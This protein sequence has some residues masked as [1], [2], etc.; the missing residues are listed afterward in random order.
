MSLDT[1][2]EP[3]SEPAGGQLSAR[4]ED[5]ESKRRRMGELQTIPEGRDL[6]GGAPTAFLPLE[7]ETLRYPRFQ[8]MREEM[9]P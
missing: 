3:Q 1:I 7:P 8:T 2:S 9:E 5:S 4:S 6:P